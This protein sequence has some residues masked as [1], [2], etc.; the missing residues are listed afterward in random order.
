MENLFDYS[1][2]CNTLELVFKS[3]ASGY[4]ETFQL[5]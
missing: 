1:E 5:E 4:K 3:H 2:F